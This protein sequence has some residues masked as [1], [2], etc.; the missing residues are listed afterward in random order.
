MTT[1]ITTLKTKEELF[2]Y[3]L[4]I[5]ISRIDIYINILGLDKHQIARL[6]EDYSILFSAFLLIKDYFNMDSELNEFIYK[7]CFGEE[8]TISIPTKLAT[9][10]NYNHFITCGIT[11][12]FNIIVEDINKSELINELYHLYI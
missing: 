8:E 2:I 10:N 1:M 12:R 4:G 5:F 7:M 6:K 3:Q 9:A 11:N